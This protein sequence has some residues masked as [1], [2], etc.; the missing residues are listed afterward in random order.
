[1]PASAGRI[2]WSFRQLPDKGESLVELVSRPE[3]DRIPPLPVQTLTYRKPDGSQ[4][5]DLCLDPA[6]Y[7]SVFPGQP[8]AQGAGG[9]Q[10]AKQRPL[11]NDAF[12]EETTKVA[13]KKKIPSWY[14]IVKND[15]AIGP[16]SRALHGRA[17]ARPHGRG[18]R[19]APGDGDQPEAGDSPDRARRAGHPGAR[20]AAEVSAGRRIQGM[21]SVVVPQA[22]ANVPG[23]VVPTSSH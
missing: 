8:A 21:L 9:L 5:I 15:R 1:M 13:W 18:E 16:G 23:L 11:S 17:G 2:L 3:P 19:P 20:D 14:P 12:T 22:R 6:Q 10:A 7:P 4:G